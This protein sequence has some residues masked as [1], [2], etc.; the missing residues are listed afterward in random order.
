MIVAE[1]ICGKNLMTGFTVSGHAGYNTNGN[2]IACA[3]VSSAVQFAAILITEIFKV[4]SDVYVGD[5]I[6]RFK[7]CSESEQAGKIISGLKL[8]LELL[9]QEF[10]KTIN[11]KI[12]EV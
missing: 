9:S 10:P 8:Q 1:F 12:L 2:D 5:D 3:S 4:K 11:I 6:I 7:L